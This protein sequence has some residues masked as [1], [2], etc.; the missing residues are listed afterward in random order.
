MQENGIHEW[1]KLLER[2]DRRLTLP[3]I[4]GALRENSVIPMDGGDFDQVCE[5]FQ[6][7]ATHP[8]QPSRTSGEKRVVYGQICCDLRVPV[9]SI[10]DEEYTRSCRARFPANKV[11]G[12]HLCFSTEVEEKAGLSLDEVARRVFE[13]YDHR[14]A[15]SSKR[16]SRDRWEW[17]AFDEKDRSV[18]RAALG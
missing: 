8:I 18:I 16:Y 11:G 9:F 6:D 17:R 4:I 2:D 12:I 13:K 1:V 5:L 15:L 10:W 7:M 3:F 14:F